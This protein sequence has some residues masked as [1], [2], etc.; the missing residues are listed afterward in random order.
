MPSDHPGAPIAG[1]DANVFLSALAFDDLP[2]RV[3]DRLLAGEFAHVTGENILAEVRR[4]AI[5]KLKLPA[6]RVDA[7]LDDIRSASSVYVP[8][9][10]MT[11]IPH[12]KDNAVLEIAFAGSCTVRVTGDLSISC[13]CRHFVGWSSSRRRRFSNDYVSRGSSRDAARH[14]AVYQIASRFSLEYARMFG[15][16][17]S[18]HAAKVR[19]TVALAF[20]T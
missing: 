2:E 15:D 13:H 14:R 7:T 17:P 16:A 1:V 18:R 11:Y 20:D 3:V 10:Q 12:A 6:A 8:S 19:R 4:N 9:G 5:G